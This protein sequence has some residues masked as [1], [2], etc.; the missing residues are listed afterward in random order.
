MKEE[1]CA[2]PLA[3]FSSSLSLRPLA[4]RSLA[5]LNE[6]SFHSYSAI[7]GYGAQP[8]RRDERE[9]NQSIIFKEKVKE[10]MEEKLN[11]SE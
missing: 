7:A 9:V 6:I 8:M 2:A 4:A 10:L 5:P 3:C 1:N 11:W